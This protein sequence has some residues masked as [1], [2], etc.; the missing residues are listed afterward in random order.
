[1]TTT[2]DTVV[3]H[4]HTV[5][6]F[7]CCP[8]CSQASQHR[9]STYRRTLADVPWNRVSVR[10]HLQARKFFCDNPTCRRHIFTEPLPDLADRYAR[11]TKRL[12]GV[13]Y[14]LGY[15]LGGEAGARMAI[16]LGLVVSPDT[17]LSCLR[18]VSQ[19]AQ[20]ASTPVRVVGVDDWAFRRRHR[21]GTILVDLEARQV[22]DLL[23]DRTAESLTEWLQTHPDVEI[24]SRDRADAYREGIRQGAPQAQQVVDRWHVLRN[25]G[26]AFERLLQRHQTHLREAMGHLPAALPP[27][28]LPTGRPV[29][30]PK[31]S[32]PPTRQE[33]E[34]QATQAKRQA[35]YEGFQRL[36]QAGFSLR[37]IALRTG[38]HWHTVRRSLQDPQGPPPPVLRRGTQPGL[39][40]PFLPWLQQQWQAGCHNGAQ[41]FRQLQAQGYPGGYTILTDHLRSWPA[42]GSASDPPGS[43]R[44]PEQVP[45]PA[46]VR[47]WLLAAAPPDNAAPP[48]WQQAF[49]SALHQQCPQITE[50]QTLAHA[51]QRLV[52][53]RAAPDLEPWL[54][55]AE[56]SAIPELVSFAKG[57]RQDQPAVTNALTLPWSNGPTEGHIHRLKLLKRQMYGRAKLDLLRARV[58]P[59]CPV[60]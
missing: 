23:P 43:Q 46:A 50:A 19:G 48:A 29:S 60:A 24:V 36:H 21:Y 45:S 7:A 6:P 39:L 30:E 57:L 32:P 20:P 52:Q 35:R 11:Q 3:L 4:M 38:H 28:P 54:V 41:L 2:S 15:A 40:T 10:I 56:T 47:W 18:R 1:M 25:L 53:D 26:D 51:F 49:L 14:S 55:Q 22:I 31:A 59:M 34:R 27:L 9:H 12:Q 44:A 33:Q 13:L 58:L 17:L 8:V 16:C 37:A 42:P 5:A